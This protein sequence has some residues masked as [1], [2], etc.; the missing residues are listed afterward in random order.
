[1]LSRADAHD[2]A[3]WLRGACQLQ[4][5]QTGGPRSRSAPPVSQHVARSCLPFTAGAQVTPEEAAEHAA[6]QSAGN[7]SSDTLTELLGTEL[8]GKNGE[9]VPLSAV[10]GKNKVL[11]IYFSAHCEAA[12]AGIALTVIVAVVRMMRRVSEG[13]AVLHKRTLGWRNGLSGRQADRHPE[14]LCGPS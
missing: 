14:N 4:R 8:L 1:M 6:K 9:R 13:C 3:A 11:G 12:G 2:A 5:R 10:T 7:S